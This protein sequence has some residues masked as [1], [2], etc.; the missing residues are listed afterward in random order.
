MPI[1]YFGR[2]KA[3]HA[4][5]C[6]QLAEA[7]AKSR[8]KRKAV[9]IAA[10]NIQGRG[11]TPKPPP[12]K[13]GEPAPPA[14]VLHASERAKR[15]KAEHGF[16]NVATAAVC[17]RTGEAAAVAAGTRQR[18]A[19]NA[20]PSREEV[21]A[22]SR[23]P[24]QHR[25]AALPPLTGG[26]APPVAAFEPMSTRQRRR[27]PMWQ[28]TYKF[29]EEEHSAEVLISRVLNKGAPAMLIR[30]PAGSAAAGW[31][32][33]VPV[34]KEGL[35]VDPSQLRVWVEAGLQDSHGQLSP[36]PTRLLPLYRGLYEVR[37]LRRCL[38]LRSLACTLTLKMSAYVQE[39]FAAGWANEFHM[40]R[41]KHD[42]LRELM[43][44]IEIGWSIDSSE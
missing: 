36:A 19:R 43:K 20:M 24:V 8:L 29:P 3:R 14:P 41:R 4:A 31:A 17:A 1:D 10:W 11:L 33:C 34:H 28:K 26:E 27:L 2:D 9:G 21:Q 5:R 37:A 35:G 40:R 23:P 38:C 44:S 12:L 30:P 39:M 13:R 7:A 42:P 18:G 6:Q 32:V 22:Q 16:Y 15:L 25:L